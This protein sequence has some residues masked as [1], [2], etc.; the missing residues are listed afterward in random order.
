MMS[1]ELTNES[2]PACEYNTLGYCVCEGHG[3]VY[4]GTEK[5]DIKHTLR[6]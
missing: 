4:M 1:P 5:G 6:W 2:E 3:T